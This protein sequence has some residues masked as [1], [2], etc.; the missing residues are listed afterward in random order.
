MIRFRLRLADLASASFACSALQE[1]ALSLRMWTHP[2]RY[3][4]QTAWFQRIR[5]DFE[6]LECRELL[7][8]LVA[9][10]VFMPDFLTPRPT[11]PWP[12]F[13][14]ELAVVRATPPELVRPDLERTFLPHDRVIPAPLADGLGDPVA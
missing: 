13:H 12:D 3:V 8:S 7:L 14:D 1:A 2:G 10:N 11:T 4:E 9:S 6:A 5:P